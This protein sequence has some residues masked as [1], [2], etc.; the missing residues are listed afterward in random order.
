MSA[1]ELDLRIQ[2]TDYDA[3]D[4]C[5]KVTRYFDGVYFSINHQRSGRFGRAF[6]PMFRRG[7]NSI[8]SRCV[9]L[10]AKAPV[11]S[12]LDLGCGT[13][14]LLELLRHRGI[15][16][17]T[18]VDSSIRSLALA[19]ARLK[20]RD[21]FR[22]ETADLKSCRALHERHDAVLCI[23]V[24]DYYAL[25]QHFLQRLFSCANELVVI[26]VPARVVTPRRLLRL[27]WLVGQGIHLHAHSRDDLGKLAARA[28]SCTWSIEVNCPPQQDN[29]WLVGQRDAGAAC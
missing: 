11:A 5:A 12:V 24:F 19:R 26:T 29:L 18:G 25:E 1:P 28:A 8:H 6:A 17:G 27:A 9:E 4:Q 16:S 23:G 13:G 22:F 14:E 20:G 2:Q 7:T 15:L 10:V 3:Q 21:S